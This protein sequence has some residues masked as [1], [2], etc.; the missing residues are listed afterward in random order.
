MG[1]G[2]PQRSHKSTVLYS[3]RIRLTNKS[4]RYVQL[5]IVAEGLEEMFVRYP[6]VPHPVEQILCPGVVHRKLDELASHCHVR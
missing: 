5:W 2:A 6:D 4:S 1:G 3:R